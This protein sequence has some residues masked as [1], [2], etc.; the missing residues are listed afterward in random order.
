MKKSEILLIEFKFLILFKILNSFN[1]IISIENGEP[2]HSKKEH[3]RMN[4]LH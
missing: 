4:P 1:D 3:N 2:K